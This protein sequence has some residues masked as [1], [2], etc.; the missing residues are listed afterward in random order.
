MRKILL[1]TTAVI[2]A[3]LLGATAAQAQT[4]P[5]VRVGGFLQ[6]LGHYINDDADE[7]N[8][9]GTGAGGG[10]LNTRDNF[11]FRTELEVVV[12]VAGKAANGLGYG[13]VIEL[14]NDGGN[15]GNTNIDTDEAYIFV[16][17]PTLGSIRFGEEDSA[18]S[19]LAVRHPSVANSGS[20][21]DFDDMSGGNS[22]MT[23][24]NDGNDATKIIYLSPQFFGFDFGASYAANGFEGDRANAGASS[25][26]DRTGLTDEI[27]GAIRYR[28]SFGNVG[29]AAAFGAM[30]ANA[31]EL[32]GGGATIT[33]SN[34]DITAYTLGAS[35]A[36]FGITFGGEYMFGSYSGGAVGRA[37]LAANRDDS[38]HYVL[39]ATYVSG[40]FQVGAWFGQAQQD[41]GPTASDR[42]QT[43]YGVGVVYN[44][45]PGLDTFA[46]YGHLSDENVAGTAFAN[47][48]RE[49]DSFI[50]GLRLAF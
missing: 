2:G 45:A 30:R 25:Q 6:V 42:K 31:A 7:P 9:A 17:S 4:A 13:A 36:A 27:A 15:G 18:A 33:P 46:N 48:T 16:T 39:G 8:G 1:G 43:G 32:T 21:G 24:I 23:G 28:G 38:S 26:R 41:N 3:A 40:P 37:P 12:S 5:T 19:L 29:L 47:S 50:A 14:Q 49:L 22:L 20:D 34:R 11:D 10:N 44:L 35:I